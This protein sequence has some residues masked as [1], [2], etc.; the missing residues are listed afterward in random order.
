MNDT[1]VQCARRYARKRDGFTLIELM[2][3]VGIIGV[4]AAIAYPSLTAYIHKSRCAEAAAFLGQIKLHQEAFRAE[5]G[6]YVGSSAGPTPGSIAFVPTP[7]SD[8]SAIPF[9]PVGTADQVFWEQLGARPDSNVRF[10][11]GWASGNPGDMSGTVL[12]G[13]PPDMWFISQAV[14]DVDADGTQ[15]T[16]E[17][18]SSS[19]AIWMSNQRGWD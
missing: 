6:Q 8:G 10:G 1:A 14:G 3:V 7:P 18:Y 15:I 16:F 17:A 19:T 4:M 2:V 5:F 12:D 13:A 11:Y 9:D